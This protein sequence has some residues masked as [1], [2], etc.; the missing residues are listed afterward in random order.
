MCK[1]SNKAPGE[2][3]RLLQL[4][5][6]EHAG[7]VL[8]FYITTP[9]NLRAQASVELKRHACGLQSVNGCVQTLRM[10]TSKQ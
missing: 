7:T 6:R 5:Y 2:T 3:T 4:F 8:S 1:Q 9:Q 10:W